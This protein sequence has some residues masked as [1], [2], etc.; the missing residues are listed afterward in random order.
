ML[1]ENHPPLVILGVGVNIV[2]AP[3]SDAAQYQ[4]TCLAATGSAADAN[5]VSAKFREAL[6]AWHERWRDE[7]FTV[8]RQAWLDHASGVGEPVTVRFAD[9]RVLEGRFSG[10]D[11]T[12]AL[13]LDTPDGNRRPIFAGDVFFAA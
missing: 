9:A 3:P 2:A 10:L 6:L 11:A 5:T 4:S 13:L 1:L 8:V 12:G 7:G